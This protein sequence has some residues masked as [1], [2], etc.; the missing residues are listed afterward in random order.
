MG[1]NDIYEPQSGTDGLMS[2][3][4]WEI[5]VLWHRQHRKQS[6]KFNDSQS[7][8][9]R[10]YPFSYLYQQNALKCDIDVNQCLKLHNYMQRCSYM[11]TCINKILLIMDLINIPL[12][13]NNINEECHFFQHSKNSLEIR[14]L[15]WIASLFWHL[16]TKNLMHRALFWRTK[17]TNRT[18]GSQSVNLDKEKFTNSQCFHAT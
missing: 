17:K 6:F 10:M 1:L 9:Y 14:I 7:Y 2:S 11:C 12:N 15:P 3:S 8:L 13:L 16:V 5:W 4:A 18:L